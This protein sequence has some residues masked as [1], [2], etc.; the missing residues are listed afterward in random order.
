MSIAPDRRPV[1][2]RPHRMRDPVDDDDAVAVLGDAAQHDRDE[3]RQPALV[4]G[5]RRGWRGPRLVQLGLRAVDRAER[6]DI[7]VGGELV[8]VDLRTQ[9]PDSGG[10]YV[11]ARVRP[12]GCRSYRFLV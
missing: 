7:S 1:A 2:P 8:D 3:L 6:R 12:A 10:A 4:V 5:L 11:V 9:Q